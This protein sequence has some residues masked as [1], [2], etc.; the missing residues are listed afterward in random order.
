MKFEQKKNGNHCSFFLKKEGLEYSFRDKQT[1]FT[2][3][4]DYEQIPFES[5][6]IRE[7]NQWFRNAGALWIIIGLYS[8]YSQY[9]ANGSIRLSFWL[10]LGLGCL[11]FYFIRQTDFLI[12]DTNRGR[13]LIIND[14]TGGEVLDLIQSRRAE[15]I[16]QR[17]GNIDWA[18]DPENEIR[19]F[20][21]ME[22]RRII[23]QSEFQEIKTR[24]RLQIDKPP[25][26]QLLN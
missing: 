8:S 17:Y 5:A 6:K 10:I 16:R 26:D 23:S 22:E 14:K 1:E 24:L 20:Q 12:F 18:N 4:L 25:T 7:Q 21:W 13:I 15:Q 2:L 11:V 19:R 9:Q 3:N